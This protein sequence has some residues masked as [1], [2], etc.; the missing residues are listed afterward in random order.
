MRECDV[1]SL[2]FDLLHVHLCSIVEDRLWPLLAGFYLQSSPSSTQQ[3]TCG[4][5]HAWG[6]WIEGLAGDAG[7]CTGEVECVS[8]LILYEYLSL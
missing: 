3:S 8:A 2:M 6:L 1:H 7:R 4:Y 5:E